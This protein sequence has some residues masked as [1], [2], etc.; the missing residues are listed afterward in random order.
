MFNKQSKMLMKLQQIFSILLTKKTLK[1]WFHKKNQRLKPQQ[2]LCKCQQQIIWTVIKTKVLLWAQ[3]PILSVRNYKPH[4]A[5]LY[6]K[7]WL[8]RLK[9]SNNYSNKKINSLCTI[10]CP[11][12]FN[13][14]PI[15]QSCQMIWFIST[16]NNC[17][18][19]SWQKIMILD[20]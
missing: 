16:F 7:R 1:I 14:I 19:L 5:H 6:L 17:K 20:S 15:L 10:N 12:D 18:S 2:N 9:C 11:L 8:S 3:F 4:L 13:L